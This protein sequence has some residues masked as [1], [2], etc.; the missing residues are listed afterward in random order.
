MELN[1]SDSPFLGSSG[2]LYGV[3]FAGGANDYGTV[4]ELTP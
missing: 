1:L 2:N 4:Y 3:T